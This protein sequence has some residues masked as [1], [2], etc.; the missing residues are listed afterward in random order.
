M[1][2]LTA[3]PTIVPNSFLIQWTHSGFGTSCVEGFFFIFNLLFYVFILFISLYLFLFIS[4]LFLS[5][6]HFY[7]SFFSLF[8]KFTFFL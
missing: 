3:L 6:F 2:V 8:L 4:F 7:F 5:L 1:P